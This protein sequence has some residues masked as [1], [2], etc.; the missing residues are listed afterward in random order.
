MKETIKGGLLAAAGL[1][2]IASVASAADMRPILKAPVLAP[3]AWS[4]TGGYIGFHAGAGWGTAQAA[5]T[6]VTAEL[7]DNPGFN[8]LAFDEGTG[9]I[10][11]FN[12]PLAQ[13]QE[14]GFLFGGQAGYNLQSGMWVFG[15]E[16]DISGTNLK[17]T[18][19][20]LL[21][22][23]CTAQSDWI[24]TLA[25]RVGV[26]YDRTLFFLKGGAAWANVKYDANLN[27]GSIVQFDSNVT[28]TRFGWMIGTGVEYAI[29]QNLSAKIEYDYLDFGSKN[30]S[31]SLSPLPA[32]LG[33]DIDQKIHLVKGGLNLHFGG[34]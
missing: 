34:M 13:V 27:L 16:G 4:W 7:D 17:G 31:F 12:V 11:G 10:S 22:V 21:V 1:L 5:V 23:S 2:A 32:S 14:N 8:E 30:Y 33:V 19:P 25:G 20:C 28:D 9:T 15:I 29:T 26:T 18:A 3:P 6:S 24:A